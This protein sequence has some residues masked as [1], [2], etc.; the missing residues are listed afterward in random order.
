M[1]N[2]SLVLVNQGPGSLVFQVIGEC[3]F[4]FVM[5]S[6]G[7]PSGQYCSNLLECQMHDHISRVAHFCP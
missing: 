2:Q 5:L 7:M 6:M 3:G 4:I 1:L